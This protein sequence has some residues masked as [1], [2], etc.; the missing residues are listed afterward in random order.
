MA[1]IAEPVLGKKKLPLKKNPLLYL[2][3]Y[4]FTTWHGGES[5]ENLLKVFYI[6]ENYPDLKFIVNVNPIFCCPGLISEAIYKKVE[7][8]INLP[9]VSIMYDGTQTNKNELLSPYLHFAAEARA[10]TKI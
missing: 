2:A 9:I 3:R 4:G 6:Y 10:K 7:K 8:E 1:S 5:A